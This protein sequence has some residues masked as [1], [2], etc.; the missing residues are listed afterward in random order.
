MLA[1]VITITMLIVNITDTHQAFIT[2]Q[3]LSWILTG[4]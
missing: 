2:C 3:T 1:V 4:R